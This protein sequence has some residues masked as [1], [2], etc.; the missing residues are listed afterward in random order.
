MGMISFDIIL[1][2]LLVVVNGVFALSEMS[3]VAARKVRLQQRAEEGDRGAQ[4]ALDLAQDPAR[5]L[6]TVQIGITV[7]GITAGAFGGATLATRLAH[8]LRPLVLIGP[9]ADG[10]AFTIVVVVTA[11]LSLVLGELAPKRLALNN[12]EKFAAATAPLMRFL[13]QL[14]APFV[15]FLSFSTR[16]V[17]RIMGIKP[18]TEPPVTEEE[19]RIMI[20]QGT[21]AGVFEELEEEIV[22]HVFRLGDRRAETLITP[23]TDI[24]WLDIND[25]A[26]GIQS[27]LIQ[28]GHSYYPVADDQ[29]DKVLGLVAAQD[30]LAQW[31]L[32]SAFDLR[33][34]LRPALFVPEGLLALDLL[35]RLRETRSKAAIVMDEYGGVQGL[36]TLYD[37]LEAIVGDLPETNEIGPVGEIRADAEGWLVDGRLTMD[38]LQDEFKIKRLPADGERRYQTLGGFVMT[39]LGHIPEVG[40]SFEWEQYTY[41][42]HSMDRKRVERVRM[43]HKKPAQPSSAQPPD[44]SE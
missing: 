27:K 2:L 44:R 29:L 23:R 32:Q 19:I 30:L 5:F 8:L 38:A 20:A 40:N 26:E 1:I 10:L 43:Q 13:A 24:T 6:S 16:I 4:A 31:L 22:E 35:V 36:V 37:M 17:L 21:R 41:T 11:Y 42:V 12:P 15:S 33:A 3:I 18:T 34:A 39:R 28:G 25:D 14:G 9:Y 7:I